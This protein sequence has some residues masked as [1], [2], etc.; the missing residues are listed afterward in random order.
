MAIGER[1]LL[2][3]G[4][5]DGEEL[6]VS[7]CRENWIFFCVKMMRIDES[8]HANLTVTS[9]F[10]VYKIFTHLTRDINP[11]DRIYRLY[12]DYDRYLTCS[13]YTV[14]VQQ[15]IYRLRYDTIEEINVDSKAEY[16]A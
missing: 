15:H 1:C 14:H 6:Y 3:T 16:T 4:E 2:E 13:R 8:L 10:S 12:C 11:N 5:W 9:N 7:L